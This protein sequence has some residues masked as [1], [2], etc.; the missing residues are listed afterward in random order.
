MMVAMVSSGKMEIR[1][2]Y[3]LVDVAF[4]TAK[5]VADGRKRMESPNV[6]NQHGKIV[7]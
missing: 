7:G 6:I 3:F 1:P 4:K 5:S 2:L